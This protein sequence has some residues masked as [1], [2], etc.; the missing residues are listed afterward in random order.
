MLQ[1]H[2]QGVGP[3]G[4]EHRAYW[5]ANNISWGTEGTNSRRHMGALPPAGQWVR[6]EVDASA[7]GLEGKIVDGMAFTLHGGRASWDRTGRKVLVTATP[8]PTPTATPTPTPTATPTPTPT[9]SNSLGAPA[10][11]AA[12][13]TTA[14]AL[15]A[16]SSV[17]DAEI[18]V[19]EN[20]IEAAYV[21][22]AR[23]ANQFPVPAQIDGGLRVSLYFSRAAEALAA[24]GAVS[25]SVQNRLQITA[26]RL[27]QV[28]NLM[29]PHENG[30]ASAGDNAHASAVAAATN[31]PF[32]G[33]ANTFSS[34]SMSPVLST[35]SLGT[36]MGGDAA[37]S[38]L[39]R[40]GVVADT[41]GNKLLPFELAGA[42][43]S[44]G[45]R[46]APLLYVSPARVSFLVPQ[47]LPQGE[48]EVIVTSQDGYVSRGTATINAVAPA[49]F[50]ADA[51]GAGQA[52]VMNGSEP[53]SASFD[54]TSPHAFGTD[55]RTRV[56]LYATGISAGAPNLYADNDVRTA[57]GGT[58]ANVAES[59][60]VEA[61][62]ADGRVYHLPV[63]FAGA[64]EG[65][66]PGLDQV[67][68]LLHPELRG[69]GH[70][71]LTIIINGQRSNTAAIS[72]R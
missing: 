37:Q 24:A 40:S 22:Y 44:V 58:L 56:M 9:P 27:A 42:S 54:V 32:I 52:L 31:L 25:S 38:P 70:V 49:L 28:S 41:S 19:L 69:A 2:E 48:L 10:L 46:A 34:A 65:R 68:V 3:E 39:A 66:L 15:A 30:T 7:V 5:G 4:W 20:K 23:E 53:A 57:G 63:E 16:A 72:I 17:S 26:S 8:T 55:K 1:W 18:N 43:V 60:T 29:L 35:H 45:G 21:A 67:N 6:L 14:N 33:A 50:T 47:G 71:D 64:V 61:R 11:V 62:T 59:L 13:R 12:A 51:S 36:I